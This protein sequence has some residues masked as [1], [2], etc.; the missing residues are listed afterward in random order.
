MVI[1]TLILNNG[2]L[3]L[4]EDKGNQYFMYKTQR[5]G[6]G[7]DKGMGEISCIIENQKYLAV[8]NKIVKG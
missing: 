6:N 4:V 3:L 1:D 2:T 8:N 5:I 7:G